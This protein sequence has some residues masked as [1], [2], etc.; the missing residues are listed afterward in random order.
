MAID[1]T[2]YNA[3]VDDDGSGTVGTVIEKLTWKNV[4]LD[5]VDVEL[6]K[7]T[8]P[9]YGTWTPT[10]GGSTSY[11]SQT[12]AWAKN[13]RQIVVRGHLTINTI[14]SGNTGVISGL[15]YAADAV[16]PGVIGFFSAAAA[17]FVFVSCY[18]NGSTIT[19]C[20][21]G[22][23]SAA[24]ANPAVFFANGTYLDFMA[25]YLTP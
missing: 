9:Q 6:A 12:G 1:R 2:N 11:S 13:G 16:T 22:A 4:V 5:P 7:I 25:T 3:L 21:T 15:P 23:A 17:P 10:L 8:A 24:L 14:G 19:I 20:G 18:V